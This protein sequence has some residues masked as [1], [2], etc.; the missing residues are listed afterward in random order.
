MPILGEL[1]DQD[2]SIVDDWI[3]ESAEHAKI[4]FA[5]ATTE[6]LAWRL[7]GVA[8]DADMHELAQALWAAM[9]DIRYWKG[10]RRLQP[11][12]GSAVD[13]ISYSAW[14]EAE[15]LMRMSLKRKGKARNVVNLVLLARHVLPKSAHAGLKAWLT[16]VLRERVGALWQLDDDPRVRDER[17]GPLVSRE[18]LDPAQP[19]DEAAVSGQVDALLRGIDWK[20]N[21]YLR[22]PDELAAIGFSGTPYTL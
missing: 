19:L 17:L 5:A 11:D 9:V 20:N 16:A 18:A 15:A 1:F 14:Q 12:G 22:S 21:R 3:D 10:E 13:W 7:D 4:A 6:W 8:P 2:V